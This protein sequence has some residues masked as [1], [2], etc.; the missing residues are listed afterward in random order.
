MTGIGYS[1][2][3][4]VILNGEAQSEFTDMSV[5]QLVKVTYEIIVTILN[6]FKDL[7]QRSGTLN[8]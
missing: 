3:G 4:E 2:H 8:K 7:D 5:T 6:L 1:G